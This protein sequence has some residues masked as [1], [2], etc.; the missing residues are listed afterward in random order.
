MQDVVCYVSADQTLGTVRDF[1]NARGAAAPT[2]IRGIG[3]TLHLRLFA[4]A[5]G[6]KPYDIETL[7]AVDTWSFIMDDDWAGETT[8]KIIADNANITVSSVTDEDRTY[9]DIAVPILET[10][11]V[12]VLDWLGTQESRNGLHAQLTGY[13][14]DAEP[15]FILQI[16]NF[17]LRNRL[18]SAGEPTA[19][20][21]EYLT[22]AQ[23]RALINASGVASINGKKGVVTL[24]AADVGATPVMQIVSA[25]S[26]ITA[27]SANRYYQFSAPVSALDIAT[28]ETSP[29]EIVMRFTVAADAVDF[30]PTFPASV[31]WVNEI[32]FEAGK[33]YII[34]IVYGLAVAAEVTV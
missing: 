20:P 28:V 7:K 12:E 1:V 18:D 19:A 17:T 30:R 10:N 29:D 8:P 21:S 2:I 26:T 14:N 15:V 31:E 11:T 16:K 33:K 5:Y 3:L 34:S 9:T 24:S 27:L 23:V 6:E 32:T 4:D 22:E 13:D 25:D